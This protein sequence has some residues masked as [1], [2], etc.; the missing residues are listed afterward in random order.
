MPNHFTLIERNLEEDARMVWDMLKSRPNATTSTTSS[1]RIIRVKAFESCPRRR[2]LLSAPRK[3]L[4]A[5]ALVLVSIANVWYPKMHGEPRPH[6]LFPRAHILRVQSST[7][8][9]PNSVILKSPEIIQSASGN[10]NWD[11]EFQGVARCLETFGAY[12]LRIPILLPLMS[13]TIY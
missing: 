8:I 9:L 7:P 11:K 10:D 3:I 6:I 13:R 2:R 5:D 12:T 1:Q 4:R